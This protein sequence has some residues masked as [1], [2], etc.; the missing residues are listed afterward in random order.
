MISALAPS[1]FPYIL[2]EIRLTLVT[3]SADVDSVSILL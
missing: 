1:C 3:V 2:R